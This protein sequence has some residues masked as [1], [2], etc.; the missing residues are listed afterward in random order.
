MEKIIENNKVEMVGEFISEFTFSHKVF[1]ECFYVANFRVERISDNID[2][3]PVMVSDRLIDINDNLNGK[4]L[5]ISGQFRSYNKY[6]DGKRKLILY[7]F[8]RDYEE[9]RIYDKNQIFLDGYICKK[10]I[11]R[12]TPRGREIT[13]IF[14]AVNRPYGKTDYIPCLVWGRNARYAFGFDVGFRFHIWGRIQS[15]EYRKKL[16]E[17][18]YEMRTA[19][20]VSVSKI[21]EVNDGQRE[22]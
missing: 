22:N 21:E 17:T 16:S 13:D 18:D 9:S 4:I 6:E 1:G 7:V 10:P 12:K 11:Y 19:Y 8:I 2:I 14:L 20:E 5:K 15:R 3:I